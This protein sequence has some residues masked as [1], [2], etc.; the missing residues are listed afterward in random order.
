MYTMYI[1]LKNYY[2]LL[3]LLYF[4]H[5]K[6]VVPILFYFMHGKIFSFPLLFYFMHEQTFYVSYII[7]R[8]A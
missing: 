1:Y 6:I 4:M 7:L 2:F 5:E 3:V 8:Y